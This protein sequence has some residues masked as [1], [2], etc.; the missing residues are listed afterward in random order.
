MRRM[1]AE[2]FGDT[3]ES[4]QNT[5][6]SKM[7]GGRIHP[8]YRFRFSG[9]IELKEDQLLIEN[10]DDLNLKDINSISCTFDKNFTRFTTNYDIRLGVFTKGEPL[11]IQTDQQTYYLMINWSFFSG[12][13]DNQEWF[14]CL[15]KNIGKSYL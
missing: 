7:V 14:R 4:L 9:S 10:W 11:I 15:N 5:T 12:F 1:K 8:S 13:I 6:F 3:A 2:Y